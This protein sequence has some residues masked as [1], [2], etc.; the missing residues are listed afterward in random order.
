MEVGVLVATRT[1]APLKPDPTAQVALKAKAEAFGVQI[2]D[3]VPERG[4][5]CHVSDT[6]TTRSCAVLL[7]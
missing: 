7:L 3:R 2:P 5:K 6:P 4:M 1:T